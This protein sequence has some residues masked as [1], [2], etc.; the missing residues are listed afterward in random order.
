MESMRND[1]VADLAKRIKGAGVSYS[2]V[3]KGTHLS[4][5]TVSRAARGQAVRS[6]AMI[7]ID[8]Y[9]RELKRDTLTQ[10]ANNNNNTQH[11]GD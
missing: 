2:R 4:Y 8:F 10:Q 7:R 1:I 6:D 3:A 9:L 11:Y 5:K